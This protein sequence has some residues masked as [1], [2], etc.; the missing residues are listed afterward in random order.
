LA[1]TGRRDRHCLVLSESVRGGNVVWSR[2]C[3]FGLR[4]IARWQQAIMR[5]CS[6]KV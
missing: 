5:S 6:R 1:R 4:F 3:G 2:L